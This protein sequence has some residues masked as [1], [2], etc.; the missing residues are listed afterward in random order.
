MTKER[1][2]AIIFALLSGGIACAN[3]AIG[4]WLYVPIFGCFAAMI[5]VKH[6]IVIWVQVGAIFLCGGYIALFQ[7][8]L[9]GYAIIFMGL[10]LLY[11]AK[12]KYMPMYLGVSAFLI[13]VLSIIQV[14]ETKSPVI[15]AM[16]D[17]GVFLAYSFVVWLIFREAVEKLKQEE[18]KEHSKYMAIINEAMSVARDAIKKLDEMKEAE[19]GRREKRCS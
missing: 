15:H 14:V 17:A 5:F 12:P 8:E 18:K 4:V 9:W 13:F 19:D 11:S 16:I 6:P 7:N 10:M 2:I 3:L 1:A